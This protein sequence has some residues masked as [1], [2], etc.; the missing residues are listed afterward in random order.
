MR[1]GDSMVA[2]LR[3]VAKGVRIG[4]ILIQVREPGAPSLVYSPHFSFSFLF[5]FSP[6]LW[7]SSTLHYSALQDPFSFLFSVL[8]FLRFPVSVALKLILCAF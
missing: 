4:K 8:Y 6:A 2:G 1:A 7:L 3:D 5:S